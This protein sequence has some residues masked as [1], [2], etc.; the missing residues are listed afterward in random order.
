MKYQNEI[1]VL[2]L[3]NKWKL[4]TKSWSSDKEQVINNILSIAIEI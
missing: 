2:I 1:V 3:E 4:Q